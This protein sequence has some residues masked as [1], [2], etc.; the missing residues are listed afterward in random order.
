M[1]RVTWMSQVCRPIRT[2]TSSLQIIYHPAGQLNKTGMLH[3]PA[4][5]NPGYKGSRLA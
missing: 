3:E 2:V 5:S 4:L 1:S